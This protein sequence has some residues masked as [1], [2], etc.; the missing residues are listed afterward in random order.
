MT[1]QEKVLRTMSSVGVCNLVMGILAMVF[2]TVTGILLVI[3]GGRLLRRK[4]RVLV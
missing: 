1:G 3:N 2:G 4:N